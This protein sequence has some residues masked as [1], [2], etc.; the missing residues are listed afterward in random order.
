MCSSELI[1]YS[2]RRQRQ[3]ATSSLQT[4][5]KT[6]RGRQT[7]RQGQT[8]RMFVLNSANG[9]CLTGRERNGMLLSN[10]SHG[11][12]TRTLTHKVTYKHRL[13]VNIIVGHRVNDD[14]QRHVVPPTESRTSKHTHTHTHSHS[15]THSHTHA[16]KHTH[17]H[18]FP[19]QFP[20]VCVSSALS[21]LLP[22]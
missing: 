4:E 3:S 22:G 20:P 9:T 2:R 7:D 18:T 12:H 6:G 21:S 15:H 1:T 14:I 10:P 17:T 11:I 16:H 13:C 5:R 8:G 19:H